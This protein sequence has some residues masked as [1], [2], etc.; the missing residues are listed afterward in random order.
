MFIAIATVTKYSGTS[1]IAVLLI[2]WTTLGPHTTVKN[3][4]VLN[5][6]MEKA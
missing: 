6:E 2:I 5:S 3:R 4:G 1:I